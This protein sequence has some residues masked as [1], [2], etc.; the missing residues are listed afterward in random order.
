MQCWVIE[1][2]V[3]EEFDDC[4]LVGIVRG[5]MNNKGIFATALIINSGMPPA[6]HT[7]CLIANYQLLLNHYNWLMEK[8]QSIDSTERLK[9][10]VH[11]SIMHIYF[12]DY[13]HE[14]NHH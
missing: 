12:V 3:S 6:N 1:F 5:L 14:G 4:R 11:I 13:S 8:S 7:F 10:S 2:A 9:D